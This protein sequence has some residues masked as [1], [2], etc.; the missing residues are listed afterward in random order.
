MINNPV[1][2]SLLQKRITLGT[3]IQIGHPIIA[4]IFAKA[5]FDWIAVDC[6]H[7]DIDVKI[8]GDLVRGMSGN[9]VIPFARVKENSV[10]AIRQV[11]D[12]G[13]LGVIV[14]LVN[15]KEDAL[16][17]VKAA[18]FPPE[19]IRGFAFF[20]AN[21]WGMNFDDYAF[22]ANKNI[23]VIVMAESKEAVEN[24]DEILE[25]DGVDGVFIGPYDMSGSYNVTGNVVHPLVLEAYNK[26]TNACKVHNKSAGI[27]IV[28]PIEDSVK[29]AVSNGFNFIALGMDTVF[30]TEYTKTIVN[31]ALKNIKKEDL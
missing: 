27:H 30:L 23:A 9:N 26:I 11:L 6:E 17:A 8:F 13:A 24:I 2:D 14:P 5:G 16:K 20:K 3:W 18:K 15:N 1:K 10:M 29:A 31:N 25:V 19:G 7:T 28:K 4:E 21:D 22:Y 12:M